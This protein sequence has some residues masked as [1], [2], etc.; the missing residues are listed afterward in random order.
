MNTLFRCE[1]IETS[2]LKEYV[3][4]LGY[5]KEVLHDVKVTETGLTQGLTPFRKLCGDSARTKENGVVWSRRAVRWT[6]RW[7]STT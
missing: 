2:T 6:L 1:N 4:S 3:Y 7:F 5:L